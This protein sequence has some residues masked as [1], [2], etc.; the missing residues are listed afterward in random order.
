[1]EFHPHDILK[2]KSEEDLICDSLLPDWV[3]E[4]LSRAPFVVVRRAPLMKK[5]VPIG[6]RGES[7]SERFAAFIPY[8]KILETIT[9]EQLAEKTTWEQNERFHCIDAL[10]SL[11]HVSKTLSRFSVKWGPTG[12][13]GFE[14]ASNVCTAKPTSDLDLV[15]RTTNLLPLEL[16]VDLKNQI[17]KVEVRVDVQ[18]ETP[19]GAISLDEYSKGKS[20]VLLRTE[21][22]PQLV[23]IQ[24]IWNN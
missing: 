1:M 23:E 20:P 9:P 16:A 2:L 11:P 24:K 22:G 3:K 4:S 17:S 19:K 5:L 15:V 14:L 12:S 8:D 18:L 13:V 6:I 7:R 10:Q 21:N